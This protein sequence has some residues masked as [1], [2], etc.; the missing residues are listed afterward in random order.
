MPTNPAPSE[1]T[2]ELLRT[3]VAFD[4]TSRNSNFPLIEFVEG[5]LS[6]LGIESRRVL[7]T[8]N[9][10]NLY[11][12]I[13]PADREGI[14]LS[15][16]TDVVPVE[17]Q[18]WATDPW[19]LTEQDGRLYGRG[20]ADM[21]GFLAVVLAAL[22]KFLAADL[23]TPLHL[24]CSPD[25]EVG[26]V[27]VLPLLAD[28]KAS[29]RR[30]K[31]AIIGEPSS[32]GVIV[33]H[34]G[35]Y[36]YRCH[37]RGIEAHS[38]FAPRAVNAI[39]YGARLVTRI[40][41]IARRKADAGPFDEAFPVAHT[42]LHTGVF[43]GGT[44]FNIVPHHA[45]FDF[46]I[47]TVGTDTDVELFGEIESYANNELLPEMRTVYPDAAITFE[48]LSSTRGLDTDPTEDVVAEVLELTAGLGSAAGTIGKVNYATEAGLF[49]AAG[50]PAVVC[51]PGSIDQ[52]HGPNEYVDLDQLALAEV[53]MD[54]LLERLKR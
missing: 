10:A 12:T 19:T 14:A 41:D 9:K 37:I 20:T 38:S 6:D 36:A 15:A 54:R 2:L 52:A 44:A 45:H 3:L 27:G 11:A 28:L 13:G 35:H 49:Q 50:I 39:E 30:P 40:N 33:A 16:H 4:T 21:K 17:G 18:D 46:E 22:P 5:Y 29:D 7:H 53:F 26:C 8:E 23:E 1:A 24:V 25:E 43:Q 51:G 31:M 48:V 34:K 42:T 32:M 47:R